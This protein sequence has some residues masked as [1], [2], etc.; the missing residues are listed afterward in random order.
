MPKHLPT[1]IENSPKWAAELTLRERRFVEEYVIDLNGRAAAVRAGLGK[2]VKSATEIASRMRKRAPVAAAINILMAQRYSETAVSIVDKMACIA[3]ASITDFVGIKGGELV[4]TDLEQLTEDQ[5]FAIEEISQTTDDD[6]RPI[7]RIK[8]YDKLSAIDKLAKV[9][10]L[11]KE[12]PLAPPPGHDEDAVESA[13]ERII[14]RMEQLARN[15]KAEEEATVTVEPPF[16]RIATSAKP[17]PITIDAEAV[18]EAD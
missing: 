4:V 9:Y 15:L 17:A 16:K 12:R 1:K 6:G 3:N 7:I 10:G 2:T 13:R 11:Y 18:A 14:A 8:L 5:K